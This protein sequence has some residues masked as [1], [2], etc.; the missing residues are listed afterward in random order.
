[1]QACAHVPDGEL[2]PKESSLTRPSEGVVVGIVVIAADG[3][4][5]FGLGSTDQTALS[6]RP[7]G[8]LDQRLHLIPAHGDLSVSEGGLT[9]NARPF[10]FRLPAGT[11]RFHSL[12]V[13]VVGRELIGSKRENVCNWFTSPP[14]C[15]WK[16]S[17]VYRDYDFWQERTLPPATFEVKAGAVTYI[18]RI[19]LVTHTMEYKSRQERDLACSEKGRAKLSSGWR[20]HFQQV[21]VGRDAD[22]DLPLIRQRYPGFAALEIEQQPLHFQPG[23]WRSVIQARQAPSYD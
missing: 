9:A 13:R 11:A 10:A 7:W 15:E 16:D 20:C 4:A 6:F 5:P 3:F 19:G 18:G 1:M 14:K 2:S 23:T 21:I 17:P 12:D 8:N 22:V